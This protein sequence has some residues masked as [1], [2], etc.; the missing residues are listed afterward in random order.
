[1][2]L[3]NLLL[4]LTERHIDFNFIDGDKDGYEEIIDDIT[5]VLN[6]ECD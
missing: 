5:Y 2:L 1:M 6:K 3:V 4:S